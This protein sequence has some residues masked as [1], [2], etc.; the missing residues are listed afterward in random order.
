MTR[1]THHYILHTAQF[2]VCK[3]LNESEKGNRLA[4]KYWP[5]A[6][7]EWIRALVYIKLH[8]MRAFPMAAFSIMRFRPNKS[9]SPPS[10]SSP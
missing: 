3:E 5:G 1:K 9:I 8:Y 10:P 2:D 7:I 4:Q 6:R